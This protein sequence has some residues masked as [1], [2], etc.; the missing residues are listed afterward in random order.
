M[1]KSTTVREGHDEYRQILLDRRREVLSGLSVRFDTMA[2]MGP[3]A[4]D[5]RAQITHSEFLSLHRNRMDYS[6]LRLVEEA[7]DRIESGDYGVCLECEEPIAP[8]RLRALSWA[9]YCVRCQDK[10][11]AGTT[12]L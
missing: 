9:R 12:L 7:L 11:A 2:S 6:Q 1:K 8:K 3:I 10:M 5:D 4:E